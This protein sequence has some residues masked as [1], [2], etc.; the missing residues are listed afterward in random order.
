MNVESKILNAMQTP[1]SEEDVDRLSDLLSNPAEFAKCIA[2]LR[3]RRTPDKEARDRDDP[4]DDVVMAI[5]KHGLAG[6]Y[7]I[8]PERFL[9]FAFHPEALERARERLEQVCNQQLGQLAW[10]RER[11]TLTTVAKKAPEKFLP[12]LSEITRAMI[13]MVTFKGPAPTHSE[14]MAHFREMHIVD[15]IGEEGVITVRTEFA[16]WCTAKGCAD[17][18]AVLTFDIPKVAKDLGLTNTYCEVQISC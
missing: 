13:R 9:G 14:V 4:C 8:S 1:W 16:A 12:I 6:A 7:V 10:K 2:D 18:E 3:S 17:E 11:A 5:A 15:R